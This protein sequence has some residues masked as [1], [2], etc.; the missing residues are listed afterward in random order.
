MVGKHIPDLEKLASKIFTFRGVS[1]VLSQEVA[2]DLEFA[3]HL[4]QR[5][6]GLLRFIMENSYIYLRS[7]AKLAFISQRIF[8]YLI[9]EGFC[10]EDDKEEDQKQQEQEQ[11]DEKYLDGMGMGDGKGGKENVSKEIE[12]EE[13]LEGLKNYESDQEKEKEEKQ[14]EDKEE[15]KDEDKDNDFEMQNDFSG[16]LEDKPDDE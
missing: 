12:H 7:L 5:V 1:S 4:V 15:Q 13:Q 8:I 11:E 3:S 16:D 9:F 14:E 2:V 6:S 10:G